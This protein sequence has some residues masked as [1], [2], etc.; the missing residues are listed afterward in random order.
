MHGV[1]LAFGLIVPLGVQNVF[2]F[3]QGA[4][5]Q[6]LLGALPSVITAA[7]CD[8]ILIALA[9]L[10]VS[11]L[12]FE[13]AWLKN[14]IFSIGFIFL[15]YMGWVTWKR[16][17]VNTDARHRIFSVKR[18]ILFAMSVS[19][20]NPHAIID[21]VVVIGTNAIAYSDYAKL[22]Y[23]LSCIAVSWLWFFSLSFAGYS[24]HKID[25]KGIWIK[26]VNKIAALIIWGIALYLAWQLLND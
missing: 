23:T 7:L 24:M 5:A 1:L 9:V 13:I 6:S 10:G 3:N 14:A 22:A 15:M 17:A 20:L 26:A 25:K 16:H 18:Q 8:T 2:I 4:A 19:I 11:I 12:I 21:T